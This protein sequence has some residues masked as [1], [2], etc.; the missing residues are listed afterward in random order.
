MARRGVLASAISLA[1]IAA[2]GIA[3]RLYMDR[4]AENRLRP[5]EDTAAA[6]LRGVLPPNAALACPPGYCSVAG[7]V[8]SPEFAVP[9]AILYRDY[10]Q[11]LAAAPRVVTVV[12]EPPRRLVAIQHSAFLRFPDIVSAEF[13]ALGADRS[14]LALY[15][16]A[17]YGR[18]DFGV[19]RRRVATWLA[20]LAAKAAPQ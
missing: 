5:G 10:V 15:S 20:R 7:A 1:A 6:A 18:Y 9:A 17:R 11:L 16:R 13:V 12:A 14:S 8:T 19:N 3:L 4:P 2:A